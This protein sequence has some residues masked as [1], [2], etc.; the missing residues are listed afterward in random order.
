MSRSQRCLRHTVYLNA[1]RKKNGGCWSNLSASYIDN[2]F[3]N[4]HL[5]ISVLVFVRWQLI[6]QHRLATFQFEPCETLLLYLLHV[7]LATP[8][9]S[10]NDGAMFLILCCGQIPFQRWI[11]VVEYLAVRLLWSERD[12]MHI[13]THKLFI[14]KI[15]LYNRRQN[16]E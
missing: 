8:F 1:S 3:R 15:T 12:H 11:E 6:H 9:R 7:S 14:F 16:A 5:L 2:V 10:F 4:I 13:R